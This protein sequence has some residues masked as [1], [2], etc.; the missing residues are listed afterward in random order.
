MTRRH[1]LRIGRRLDKL[2]NS[3]NMIGNAQRHRRRHADCLV[4]PAQVVVSDVEAHR[5]PVVPKLLAKPV[6]Q[7]REAALLHP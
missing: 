1:S 7:P 6:G 3:P 2:S 4:D 5:C